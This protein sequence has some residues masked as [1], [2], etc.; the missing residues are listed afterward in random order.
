VED[1]KNAGNPPPVSNVNGEG[2][3]DIP[4]ESLEDTI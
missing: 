4:V 1:Y 2:S 3:Q